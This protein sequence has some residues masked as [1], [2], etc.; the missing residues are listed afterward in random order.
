MTNRSSRPDRCMRAHDNL[1]IRA[2]VLLLGL[3]VSV[4][5]VSGCSGGSD[6]GS[7]TSSGDGRSSTATGSSTATTGS[8]EP[9]GSAQA[10]N[11]SS[12]ASA[13][14]TLQQKDLKVG[15]GKTAHMGEKVSLEFTAW[16]L[17]GTEF[18]SSKKNGHPLTFTIGERTVIF[19][20]D[21]GVRG[22]KVGGVRELIIPSAF[23]YGEARHGIVPPGSTLKFKVKL[24]SV[25]RP[26]DSH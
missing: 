8:T 9:S 12:V 13:A 22:M 23:G 21:A 19:G 25:E 20:L 24:L 11:T 26:T 3:A 15:K 2:A 5:A 18:A 16:L 10:T 4:F 1:R 14:P 17:D 6:A 7:K